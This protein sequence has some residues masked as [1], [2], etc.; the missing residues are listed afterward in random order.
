MSAPQTLRP[1]QEDCVRAILMA[2]ERRSDR[3]RVR[4]LGS[5]ATGGGKTTII[6]ELLRRSIDPQKQRALVFVHRREIVHQI[7]ERIANQFSELEPAYR[8]DGK[9]LPG[10]GIVM[11]DYHDYEARIVVASQQS[12][13][14]NRLGR[15][16]QAGKF[17]VVIVDESHHY[18][19]DNTYHNILQRLV[20]ENTDI[21]IAG[22]TATPK[23]SDRRALKAGF[24]EIVYEWSIFDGIAGEHLV[25][26]TRLRVTT[27]VDLSAI[28]SVNGDYQKNQMLSILDAANWL[29]LAMDAYQTYL[30]GKRRHILAFLPSVQMSRAFTERLKA[31][32]VAAAHIDAKT[33]IRATNP[34]DQHQTRPEILRAFKTGELEVVCNYNVL[35]EGFDAPLVDAIIDA[36]PS[37][38][39][40]VKTQMW[41]RGLRPAPGKT[42]CLILDLTV[43]DVNA[44]ERGTLL[45]KTRQCGQCGVQFFLGFK[46][47]PNC[48]ASHESSTKPEQG[49]GTGQFIRH[50]KRILMGDLQAEIVPLFDRLSSA[51]FRADDGTEMMSSAVNDGALVIVPPSFADPTRLRERLRKGDY[52]LP[53]LDDPEDRKELLHQM[54]ILRRQVERCEA[55]TLYYVCDRKVEFI[56]ANTDLASLIAEADLEALRRAGENSYLTKKNS[57]WRNPHIPATPKQIN[58]LR[59]ILRL[60]AQ[61]WN[62]QLSKDQAARLITHYKAA[63]FVR[64]F[65]ENDCLPEPASHEQPA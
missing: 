48:H 18:A 28:K 64:N 47:C 50:S 21:K 49:D 23:R 7:R 39:D 29:D 59:Y 42:D 46:V 41:G 31:E 3:G 1:Y 40:T 61:V 36:R 4:A 25:P 34:A 54:G 45:G 58:M 56:R 13:N 65:I 30:H 24:D 37:R 43:A 12:L 55:Y 27:G 60:P 33:P 15:L 10:I 32:G 51:W 11:A 19:P 5:L 17:D 16:L 52:L 22:F 38:S 26:A 9:L 2:W 35:T 57:R 8:I 62:Q 20:A 53:R 63:P 44:L 14:M 6:G